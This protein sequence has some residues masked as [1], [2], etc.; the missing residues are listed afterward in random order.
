MGNCGRTVEDPPSGLYYG[1]FIWS[2]HSDD[3]EVW[4]PREAERLG[5]QEEVMEESERL[6]DLRR[7]GTGSPLNP[8]ALI[9]LTPG[10]PGGAY[11]PDDQGAADRGLGGWG[12][13]QINSFLIGA[14]YLRLQM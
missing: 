14:S 5:R 12:M 10:C 11:H 13:G 9:L 4:K 1:T 2:L 8:P 6:F 3:T 7:G